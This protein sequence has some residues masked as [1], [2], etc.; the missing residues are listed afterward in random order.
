[1]RPTSQPHDSG[2]REIPGACNLETWSNAEW[3]GGIQVDRMKDLDTV[4][5]ETLNSTYEITVINGIEGEV[6]VRGGQFFPELTAARLSGAS[7]G[8]SFLK[9]RGIYV[10]FR[11]EILHEG[12]CIITSPV[13]TIAI[14]TN[15]SLIAPSSPL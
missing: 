11:M 10:G 13:R 14:R 12:Q 3:N 2:I 5:V 9:V 1:M 15:T 8:G 4:I 7:M 6:V